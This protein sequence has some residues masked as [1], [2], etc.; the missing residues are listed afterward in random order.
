M[1]VDNDGIV[2]YSD[3][4]NYGKK[5][6]AK[7]RQWKWFFVASIVLLL[8]TYA[9]IFG[10]FI[11]GFELTKTID[12]TKDN[13]SNYALI[14]NDGNYVSTLTGTHYVDFRS[15]WYGNINGSVNFG[16]LDTFE[17]IFDDKYINFDVS[18]YE[19]NWNPDYM[20]VYDSSGKMKIDYFYN[21]TYSY[22]IFEKIFNNGTIKQYYV[23]D[24]HMDYRDRRRL[25]SDVDDTYQS[26]DTCNNDDDVYIQQR[27]R[28]RLNSY[29]RRLTA[30][31][32]EFPPDVEDF[33]LGSPPLVEDLPTLECD[34]L[35]S[36]S[37]QLF[38]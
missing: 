13:N 23:K 11:L 27:R 28:R 3:A 7:T 21:W 6:Q 29:R 1:D 37:S 16:R 9:I 20:T 33:R 26:L 12:V 4:A 17:L 15:F 2:T 35:F 18:S 8:I 24:T 31:K 19:V 30:D 14:S 22:Y 38:C 36:A 5:A 34:N 25:A 10:L 32:C